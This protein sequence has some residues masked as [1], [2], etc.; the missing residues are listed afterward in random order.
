ML[1]PQMKQLSGPVVCDLF[2]TRSIPAPSLVADV[3]SCSSSSFDISALSFAR[4]TLIT[5]RLN[6]S[7]PNHIG[8]VLFRRSSMDVRNVWVLRAVVPVQRLLAIRPGTS[9]RFGH[10][11]V[12]YRFSQPMQT[13]G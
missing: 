12:M 8:T 3:D 5:S 10:Q 2:A 7:I 6:V 4:F 13:L 9:P 1:A 11:L